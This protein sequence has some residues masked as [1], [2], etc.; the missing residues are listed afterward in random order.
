MVRLRARLAVRR[1][2]QAS[3]RSGP[4]VDVPCAGRR[5]PRL[6]TGADPFVF[7]LVVT[8]AASTAFVC[9]GSVPEQ[10][11]PG[12]ADQ[13]S[14]SIFR[15]RASAILGMVTVRT[16]SSNVAEMSSASTVEGTVKERENSP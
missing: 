2:S 8:F 5:P 7:V 11:P 10:R 14:I 6:R 3:A 16:P 4:G 1:L 9:P 15:P 12:P 13:P